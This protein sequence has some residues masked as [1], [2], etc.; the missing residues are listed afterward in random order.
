MPPK[1][2]EKSRE[3][4]NVAKFGRVKN[5]L[6]MGVVGLPNVG[7][8]SLFN[9]LTN[10]NVDAANFPFC[11]I[12]PNE[13]R[14]AVPD[15]RYDYLCDLWKSPS[16]VPAYLMVTDIAGLIKGA[17]EGAG[18]GNAFL[19]HIQ[20]V[21]GIFHCVRIFEDNDVIH[22]DDSID[23][24]RDL[25]TI[26]GE[27]CKKDLAIL[28]QAVAAEEL[29]VKRSGGKFKLSPT[30]IGMTTKMQ[31]LLEKNIPVRSGEW[32]TPE[33]ELINEKMSLITTKPIVYLANMSKADF[34]RKKN[35]WLAKI[36]AWIQSH[37]GGVLIPFSVEFEQGYDQAEDKEAFL[38]DCGVE[39]IASA[40]PKIIT[41]GYSQ[42]N[43][44]NFFTAGEKEVR[45]WTVYGG[46]SA[47][48][49]AS[50]IHSDFGKLFIKAEVASYAD[51]K[52][53]CGGQKSMA[54]V[55]AAGKYRVEGKTYVVKDGDIIY[56]QIGTA[57]GKK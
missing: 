7:K 56:F 30:F 34:I 4:E 31:E 49:A 38:K 19:S 5:N 46:A 18:L 24:I 41:T 6:R 50:V 23:P 1:K 22:V 2:S 28:K 29:A 57:G 45:A 17:S 52:E 10:Q 11:T 35:K 9:L 54:N 36:H 12:D 33:I 51:F 26:Q 3:E 20:A 16:L 14:C 43:L 53:H 44:V 8:S 37:G 48:E 47:P 27:L 25:E 13:A 40:L 55:K 42:L 15:A 21:D 32:S 39:G